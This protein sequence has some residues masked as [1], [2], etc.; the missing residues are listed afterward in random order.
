MRLTNVVVQADLGCT[1]DLSVLTYHP[2]F[3]IFLRIGED[4]VDRLLW[5]GISRYS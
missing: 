2:S 3:V 1:L 5:K 4:D